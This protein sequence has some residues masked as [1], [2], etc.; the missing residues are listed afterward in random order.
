MKYEVFTSSFK[1]YRA[2]S[3]KVIVIMSILVFGFA[4]AGIDSKKTKNYNFQDGDII[5]HT[6]KSGQSM[7][8]QLAT[9]S[10]F[11]HVG[12][13]FNTPKGLMVYEAV[14][15]VRITPINKFIARGVDGVYTVR[16]LKDADEVL[17]EEAIAKM[18]AVGNKYIGMDY[19]PYFEW[20]DDRIY[21]SE[22][23]WKI[24]NQALNLKIGELQE[25]RNFDLKHA[26]VQKTMKVRY[27]DNIPYDEQV[28]SPAAMFESDLLET[29]E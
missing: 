4:L 18:L 16:R 8:V 28:V 12:I 20:N 6:G 3:K 10:K 9:H 26:E 7:A 5:F 15:P 14:Q 2:I 22:Y 13:I 1:R 11:S 25:L 21:C 17:T 23:V 29:V 27:G 24:Y 19:D